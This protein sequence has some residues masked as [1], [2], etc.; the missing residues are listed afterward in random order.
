M[1]HLQRRH[2][3][4]AASAVPLGVHAHHG[5]SSFDPERPIYLEGKVLKVRW[6]NP[7]AE[8]ELEI[9]A[10]LKLPVDLA[11]RVVPAQTSPVDGKAL[12]AK[13]VLPNRKDRRWEVELAPLTRMQAWQVQEIKTGAVVS[14]VGFTL[15][16]EKGD[17]VLRAEYLF[18]DGKT[19]GLRSSPA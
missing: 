16:E 2:V 1:T 6:Q 7:H 8:L 18:V 3:L 13:A 15:R 5:W 4:L 9:P 19:Y 10:E 17:A 14:V 11:Q 12:L